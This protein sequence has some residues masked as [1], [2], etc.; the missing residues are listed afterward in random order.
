[1]ERPRARAYAP[2]PVS[3]REERFTAPGLDGVTLRA[4]HRGDP[5]WPTLV[6]LHGG[7][8]NAHWWDHVAPR[9]ALGFH[10]VAL[11]FRGHGDS[12]YPEDR[13]PGA[14]RHDLEALIEHLDT[15]RPVLVGHSLGGHVALDHAARGGKP[16]AIVAIDL[17]RGG[18]QRVRRATRLALAAARS[19]RTREEAIAR[20]RFLPPAPNASESLR[21]HV[22][23][24]SVRRLPDGRFGFKFDSR[25]FGIP[26]APRAPLEAIAAPTLVIR[27]ADSTL[28]TQKG[29][30]AYVADIPRARLAVVE[31]AGHN[32]HL[33]RPDEFL[34]AVEDF[35]RE[36]T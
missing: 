9:L 4:L 11:D 14:F 34:E 17:V 31:G 3:A 21:Y 18:G 27:G 8:A 2:A 15:P 1:M 16:R 13:R 36:M 28:L 24:H 6:L 19:Y 5:Q 26:P 20:Y 32:V 7:G 12:D 23:D 29:A 22:A 25:W 30:E 35:L 33:E 10:V